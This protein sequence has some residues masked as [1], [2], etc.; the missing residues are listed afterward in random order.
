MIRL[1]EIIESNT[2]EFVTQCYEL[3]GAPA[4][5]TIVKAGQSDP[6]FGI[7]SYTQTLA[8]DPTRRPLPRGKDLDDESEIYEQNPQLRQL[9]TTEFKSM[10]V[11]YSDQGDIKLLLSPSPPRIHSF[12][13]ESSIEDVSKISADIHFLE[14]IIYSNHQQSDDLVASFIKRVA[15]IIDRPSFINESAKKLAAILRNDTQRLNSILRRL[16]L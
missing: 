4:L 14:A 5:G 9:L 11:G 15:M 7:V 8:L 2:N 13:E 6:V 16:R 10:I 12:V 3:Y 1:G